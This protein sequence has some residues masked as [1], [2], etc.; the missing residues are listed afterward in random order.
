V[1]IIY[2]STDNISARAETIGVY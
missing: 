1:H 2:K